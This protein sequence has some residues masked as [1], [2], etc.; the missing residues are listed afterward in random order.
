MFMTTSRRIIVYGA[1][2]L[3]DNDI[4]QVMVENTVLSWLLQ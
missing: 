1:K 2:Q 4:F 3:M